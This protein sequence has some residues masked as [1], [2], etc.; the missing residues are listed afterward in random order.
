ML[1]L[2]RWSCTPAHFRANTKTSS[3]ATKSRKKT[4]FSGNALLANKAPFQ[5]QST[6]PRV[7]Q[8]SRRGRKEAALPLSARIASLAVMPV[9]PPQLA[10]TVFL[11]PPVRLVYRHAVRAVPVPCLSS[12]VRVPCPAVEQPRALS[13]QLVLLVTAAKVAFCLY[14]RQEF[15]FK[16]RT[17]ITSRARRV[18]RAAITS[19]LIT[20]LDAR[21]ATKTPS[22]RS[23]APPAAS[24]VDLASQPTVREARGNAFIWRPARTRARS[25]CLIPELKPSVMQYELKNTKH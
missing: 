5:G 22:P 12:V 3:T 16:A 4:T 10:A 7:R 20:I 14:T 15:M 24:L 1:S 8:V 2:T 21:N 6:A 17:H 11:A 23:R 19:R 25:A 18:Q 9:W 13:P